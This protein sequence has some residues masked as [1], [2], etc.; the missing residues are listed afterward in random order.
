VNL[1]RLA[2][3]EEILVDAVNDI[4]RIS[5]A[6]PMLAPLHH[7]LGMLYRAEGRLPDAIRMFDK[8]LAI[9]PANNAMAQRAAAFMGRGL[10]CA[11]MGDHGQAAHSFLMVNRELE[12]MVPSKRKLEAKICASAA[13]LKYQDFVAAEM[14]CRE[15]LELAE[16]LGIHGVHN[17]TLW[18]MLGFAHARC[19]HLPEAIQAYRTALSVLNDSSLHC[20]EEL[21]DAHFNLALLYAAT[22]R[23]S[24]ADVHLRRAADVVDTEAREMQSREAHFRR[25]FMLYFQ[26]PEARITAKELHEAMLFSQPH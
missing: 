12:S 26:R 14:V 5:E 18:N 23:P 25:V 13:L 22:E 16:I 2:D 8:A 6:S 17:A 19:Q 3:A 1:D 20:P 9:L 24:D 4:E 15:A 21:A 11:D 10:T 7:H